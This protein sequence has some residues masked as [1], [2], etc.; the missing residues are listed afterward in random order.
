MIL[1]TLPAQS[2]DVSWPTID[3]PS[4]PLPPSLGT[5]RFEAL[6][7]EAFT[8]STSEQLGETHALVVVQGGRLI[9]ERYGAKSGPDATQPSWSMAKSITHALV[10]ILVGDGKLDIHQP[11]DVPEWR[12][13]NDPRAR[14][15]WTC[16]C[17]CPAA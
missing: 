5:S 3:W 6:I 4:G 16:C 13:A 15:R 12:G 14:S 17:V 11:A 7:G 8:E 1:M 2:A 10:G 9:F